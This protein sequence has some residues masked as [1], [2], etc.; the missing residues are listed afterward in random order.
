MIQEAKPTRESV[1][2]VAREYDKI[3][4]RKFLD[5]YERGAAPDRWLVRI[6]GNL[7]PMKAIAV[8]AHTPP[9]DPSKLDYRKGISRLREVGFIDIVAVGEEDRR[10][11]RSPTRETVLRAMSEFHEIG[12]L[13][14]LTRYSEGRV[15]E[16]RY[17]NEASVYYPLKALF[18]AAHTPY[19]RHR[20]FS[21][22]DAERE[23]SALG[24]AVVVLRKSIAPVPAAVSPDLTV[25][26]GKRIIKEVKTLVR[27]R[28]IVQMA[29]AAAKP[30]V[31]EACGFD[32]EKV[33]GARGKGF[34]EAH[35][36]D[37]LSKREGKSQPTGIQD[38]A[39]LCA[40]CHRMAHYGP[41]CITVSELQA[42]IKVGN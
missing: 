22:K 1:L 31:C 5:K 39:M 14:F 24:F 17:V 2:R 19:A 37:P 12:T 6:D 42:L 26:E 20:H 7:Y 16:S 11:I 18:A 13:A 38:F 23:L 41:S 28:S 4:G 29:K 25:N 8:A 21:S 3:G 9:A 34:I 15:S 10:P 36:I 30:L 40:N 27:N 35:H 33:Y 32:F